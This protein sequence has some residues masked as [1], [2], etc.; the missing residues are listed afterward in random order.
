MSTNSLDRI[1]VTS[2]CLTDWNSM[3]GNDQVR[4]CEHCNLEVH[5]LSEMSRGKAARLVARS[6]GR[7]CVRYYRDSNDAVIT[8]PPGRKL[9]LIGRRASKIAAG[10]FT[11][12]IS[13]STATV[14]SAVNAQ[15]P[16]YE[17]RVLPDRWS[18]LGTVLGRITD[19][20]SAV[21]PGATIALSNA[22]LNLSLFTSTN[23]EGEFRF[24]GLVTGSYSLR[25]EA[26]GFA[27]TETQ[28]YIQANDE[29]RVDRELSVAGI[30]A[31]VEIESGTTTV[32]VGVVGYVAPTDPFVKAA[33][34]DDLIAVQTLI[35]ES[36]VNLRDKRSHTTALDHAVTNSNREMVQLLLS[37]GAD[38]NAQNA[39]GLAPLMMTGDDSTSDLVWDLINA[40]AKVN[41]EDDNGNTALI[42][43]ASDD[44][45]EVT[46]ALL[47]AGAGIAHRNTQGHTAL[48]MA[49]SDGSI[50][51]V[52][53]LIL[54]GANI[55]EQ[56]AE[57]KNALSYA[58]ENERRAVIRFLRS[59]GAV[60]TVARASEE[61]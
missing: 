32:T 1:T 61:K 5:N 36:D 16:S 26:P 41:L 55:D 14:Q 27:A 13:L 7:L 59:R 53:A 12:A 57:G 31:E 45:V 37:K 22:E 43:A 20:N 11:A 58:M 30:E 19:A 2:P 47:D 54:A 21:I 56:D 35:A 51:N 42:H 24:D 49:A 4:F 33:Q 10:A 6:Q 3:I 17:A 29:T 44:N 18:P 28:A 46:R 50:N 8:R 25:I 38:V 9:H 15:Q 39:N 52:R 34:E 60:E 48:M 23:H 40:G